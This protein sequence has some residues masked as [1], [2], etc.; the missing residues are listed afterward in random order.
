MDSFQR[1]YGIKLVVFKISIIDF[2][3]G[4]GVIGEGRAA[5]GEEERGDFVFLVLRPN[6]L[7][8]ALPA[9]AV[10][11]GYLVLRNPG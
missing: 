9:D 1:M 5:R 6:Y 10:G 4:D 11:E 3:H 2:Q 8:F 7:R